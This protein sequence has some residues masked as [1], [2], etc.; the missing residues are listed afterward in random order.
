[1]NEEYYFQLMN[2]IAG[3]IA[4]C[5]D[6]YK[7]LQRTKDNWNDRF[8]PTSK[9]SGLTLEE[10]TELQKHLVERQHDLFIQWYQMNEALKREGKSHYLP[11]K[12]RDIGG[13]LL[14]LSSWKDLILK[15]KG[16]K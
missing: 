10:M 12:I 15:S 8:N 7:S 9:T 6:R 11:Q 16:V 13:G 4:G 2:Y 3:D 14:E 1:M 5:R